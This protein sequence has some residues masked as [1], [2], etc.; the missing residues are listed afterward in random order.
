MKAEYTHNSD[1]S[2]FGRPI[3]VVVVVVSNFFRGISRNTQ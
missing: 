2:L 1:L 3:I